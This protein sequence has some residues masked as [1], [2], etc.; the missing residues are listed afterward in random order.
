MMAHSSIK[1]AFRI[2]VALI[3][4]F[5]VAWPAYNYEYGERSDPVLTVILI[6]TGL[7]MFFASISERYIGK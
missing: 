1:K 3:G 6:I 2:A 7:A 4:V 5:L